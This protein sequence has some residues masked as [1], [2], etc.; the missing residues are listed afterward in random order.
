MAVPLPSASTTKLTRP[1]EAE[2]TWI[3]RGIRAACRPTSQSDAFQLVVL[4]AI[5]HAMTGFDVDYTTLEPIGA[6]AFAAGLADREEIFR[7]RV[8][9]SMELGHMILCRP[10]IVT[11][12]RIIEFANALSV[13]NECIHA[14]REVA[15]GSHQLVAADFDRNQ[16]VLGLDASA[17][18]TADG[19]A[20]DVAES[21]AATR[22]DPALAARWRALGDLSPSSIGRAVFDFYRARGFAFPGEP[23]SAPPML[24]QHDWVHLLADFGTTVESELEVFGFIARASDD[25]KAFALLAMAILLFQTGQLPSAAGIF[26][27]DIGH[28]CR[29][30]MPVRLADAMRRGALCTGSIDFLA[31]NWFA[32]ADR[33]IDELRDHFGVQPKSDLAIAAGSPGPNDARGIS[34]FQLEAGRQLAEREHRAYTPPGTPT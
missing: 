29:E 22:I 34:P 16:Y 21:W 15:A 24:A 6:E 14:A 19:A 7:T 11:A 33:T 17:I 2:A 20:L 26:E 13:D 1:D 12:D 30:G 10:D 3:A 8:V 28:L 4:Q 27:A 25:P 18:P 5:T 9:Q 31:V 32:L 23:G